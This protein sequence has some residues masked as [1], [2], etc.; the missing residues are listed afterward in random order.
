MITLFVHHYP[1]PFV[2]EL[3]MYPMLKLALSLCLL[4]KA[5]LTSH[6]T[7][8][9]NARN[10]LD[11]LQKAYCKR[12]AGTIASSADCA[13]TICGKFRGHSTTTATANCGVQRGNSSYL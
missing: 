3:R 4:Q 11:L 6:F 5:S 2:G 10:G 1:E 9:K 8:I 7:L 13:H 12:F